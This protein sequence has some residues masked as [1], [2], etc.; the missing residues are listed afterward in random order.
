MGSFASELGVEFSIQLEA[1]HVINKSQ[2]SHPQESTNPY[3]S[4]K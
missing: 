4:S 3:G 2:V 1:N